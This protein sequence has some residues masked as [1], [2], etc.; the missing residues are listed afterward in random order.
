MNV[1]KDLVAASATPLI[2][3]ILSDGPSYGYAIIKRVAELSGGELEWTDGML[4]PV[5]HRLERN[6][7]VKAEWGRS[8]SGRRRKYYRLTSGGEGELAN[9]RR[10]WEL[11]D[12]TLRRMFFRSYQPAPQGG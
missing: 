3:A 11:V 6:G 8:Q 1:G 5:L 7:L 12:A 9:Q 2:L 10:Q 4:Y